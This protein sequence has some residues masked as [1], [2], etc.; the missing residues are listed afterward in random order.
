MWLLGNILSRRLAVI[1]VSYRSTVFKQAE[2]IYL[3]KNIDFLV[4]SLPI[5]KVKKCNQRCDFGRGTK[6]WDL[7]RIFL[8]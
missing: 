3:V 2:F 4:F 6:N 8:L 5:E 1:F 7:L